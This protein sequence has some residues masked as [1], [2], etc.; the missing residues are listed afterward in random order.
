MYIIVFSL[1]SA[2]VFGELGSIGTT[3]PGCPICDACNNDEFCVCGVCEP[4]APRSPTP[5]PDDSGEPTHP[6]C[7]PCLRP[8][9]ANTRCECGVCVPDV[10]RTVAPTIGCHPCVELCVNGFHCV[11]GQCVPS[12]NHS[13]V[14]PPVHGPGPCLVTCE[15]DSACALDQ[16]CCGNG[17]GRTCVNVGATTDAPTPRAPTPRPG[18]C[19]PING[20]GPCVITCEN[21]D[22]CALGFKCC[23][24]GCGRTC[25]N[26]TKGGG[27]GSVPCRK[28]GDSC[29]TS[30]IPRG[31]CNVALTCVVRR[32]P[33]PSCPRNCTCGDACTLGVDRRGI[34]MANG[35]CVF[36][37]KPNCTTHC[38]LLFCPS[39]ICHAPNVSQPTKL[40]NGCPGCPKCGPPNCTADNCPNGFCWETRCVPFSGP[41]E[42]C[43]GF[44]FPP[45]RC[46]PGLVCNMS[47]IPDVGGTCI[48]PCPTCPILTCPLEEQV[49]DTESV[50]PSHCPPCHKCPCPAGECLP[51]CPVAKT[52]N[53]L[54]CRTCPP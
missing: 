28:C 47:H 48:V 46:R 38:P 41:G 2:V 25:V 43:N 15:S 11:C 16:K 52:T 13:G 51:C 22:K 31:V 19:P 33:L 7:R 20:P 30:A 21:D 18:V 44:I 50:A 1:L 14:C 3:Q 40:P 12:A 32:V 10:I 27:G 42:G 24:N 17:C 34:C 45:R 54:P 36:G 5:N 29:S 9:P 4:V 8:C 35:A 37:G 26:V 39:N 49:P 6:G 53:Q 23:G